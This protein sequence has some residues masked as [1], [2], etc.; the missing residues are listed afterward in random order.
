MVA[1]AIVVKGVS[2]MHG[3]DGQ[4]YFHVRELGQEVRGRQVDYVY[5]MMVEA[6][7]VLLLLLMGHKGDTIDKL[8]TL[9]FIKG[10]KRGKGRLR[11][12]EDM[13]S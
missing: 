7:M 6:M 12:R 11:R 3:V 4:L 10:R 8:G 9:M 13:C 2:V 1:N 5:V